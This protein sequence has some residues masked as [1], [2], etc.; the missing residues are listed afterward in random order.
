[1]KPLT[2]S[3][4]YVYLHLELYNHITVAVK[5]L[6]KT[7][8]VNNTIIICIDGPVLEKNQIYLDLWI[9]GYRILP[10]SYTSEA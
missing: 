8:T 10:M 2:D 1:M 7:H 4:Y 9:P 5:M 3:S 6:Y